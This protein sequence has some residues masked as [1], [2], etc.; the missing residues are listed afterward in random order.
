MKTALIG[1]G[2]NV[3]DV[4][5]SFRRAVAGLAELPDA[6]VLQVSRAY[7]TRAL[8]ADAREPPGPD[9]WNA[10]VELAIPLSPHALL[11]RLQDIERVNGRVRRKRWEA[12]SLDLDLL[13]HGDHIVH[14]A[15]LTLPHPHVT[16][17]VFVLAPLADIAPHRIVGGSSIADRLAMFDP[18][19]LMEIRT[20][21]L[22]PGVP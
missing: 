17:R 11:A 18:S 12:R 21:W 15:T 7:R 6:H 2:G 13:F 19:E 4:L 3:G 5:A 22:S 8:M 10:A 20:D 9:Y 1:L 16:T 14:D